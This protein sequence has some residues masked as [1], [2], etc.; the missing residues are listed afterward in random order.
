MHVKNPLGTTEYRKE[1]IWDYEDKVDREKARW[2]YYA[3]RDRAKLTQGIREKAARDPEWYKK[4]AEI[5]RE[6][7]D[8]MH[9]ENIR[10]TRVELRE[11]AEAVGC[12]V[13]TKIPIPDSNKAIAF[14]KKVKERRDKI[15]AERYAN[16]STST[17]K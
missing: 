5:M 15:K 9:L 3:K 10:R 2:R 4:R 17:P 6:R 8:P 14:F 13:R 11:A 16:A 7:R 1:P 12:T